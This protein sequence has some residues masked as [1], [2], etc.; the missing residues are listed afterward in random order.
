MKRIVI[1]F[2]VLAISASLFAQKKINKRTIQKATEEVTSLYHLNEFQ[3][4]KV[5]EIQERRLENLAEIETIKTQDYRTYLVKCRAVRVGTES[6]IK[7]LLDERQLEIFQAQMDAR[8][9]LEVEKMQ[10]LKQRGASQSEI[11]IALLEIE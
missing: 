8:R 11:E 2:I 10:A 9:Q 4:A 1:T 3:Q 6:A 7:R 5:F